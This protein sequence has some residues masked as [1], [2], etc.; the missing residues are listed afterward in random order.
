MIYESVNIASRADR[1]HSSTRFRSE[2]RWYFSAEWKEKNSSCTRAVSL[3]RKLTICA[4]VTL[5][6]I[7]FQRVPR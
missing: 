7:F 3:L 1:L 4:I 6:V 5:I 2:I